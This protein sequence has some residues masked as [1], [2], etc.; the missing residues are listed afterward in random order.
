MRG[1]IRQRGSTW[2]AYWSTVDPATGK[3]RQH[4]RGGFRTRREAQRHLHVVLPAV[5][6][7]TWTPDARVTVAK[8]LEDWLAAKR[9]EGLRP[10]TVSLYRRAIAQWIV[11]HIG[12]VEARSLTPS[13]VAALVELLR[14]SGR[15]DGGSGLSPRSV[16][17]SVGVL[18]AATRWANE[19]GMLARDPLSGYRRPRAI[20]KPMAFWEEHEAQKFLAATAE[21]R[22]AFAWGLL[23]AR[24]LRRGE[25]CGL[26]WEDIDLDAGTLRIVRTRILVDST[27]AESAPKTA[28]GRRTIKLDVHLL[29]LLRRHRS[30]QAAEKLAAGSGYQDDGWLFADELG[31]PYHPDSLSD[32]FDDRVRALG[33]RRIRLHDCRHTAASLMLG[34]GVP[35]HV[36]AEILGHDPKVTW[37]TYAHVIPGM[38]EQAGAALSARLFGEP[39]VR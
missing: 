3:R 11:P 30:R 2:T 20:S 16:Q 18:K 29:S 14:N 13:T 17:I 26:K 1:S 35:V 31:R 12:G 9:A 5:D 36:V 38:G 28:A 15:K 39:A 23:L 19:T 27:P 4:S 33:L 24:G 7:G 32:W 8:L 34:R 37:S 25:V 10:A 21:D 22:I 6:A